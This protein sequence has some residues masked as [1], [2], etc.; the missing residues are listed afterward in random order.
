VLLELHVL[1][2]V[3]LKATGGAE[4]ERQRLGAHHLL[5]CD[6][7][8]L[9]LLQRDDLPTRR[10]DQRPVRP[11]ER[12][13]PGSASMRAL[14][15]PGLVP[16]ARTP[17]MTPFWEPL[18]LRPPGQEL[19]RTPHPASS[20]AQDAAPVY[21]C[22]YRTR[23]LQSTCAGGGAARQDLAGLELRALPRPQRLD[24]ILRLSTH[25]QRLK[26]VL[27]RL[28]A[29]VR[30][31]CPVELPS[32]SDPH[33]AAAETQRAS[34]RCARSECGREGRAGNSPKEAPQHCYNDYPLKLSRP[35]RCA[36]RS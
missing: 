16:A 25:T 27:E 18:G 24:A 20:L 4:V 13:P 22:T 35:P 31:R 8:L 15:P 12:H 7:V 17:L 29:C 6:E 34:H 30:V 3:A 9:L 36:Q 14:M 23:A 1:D 28:R 10:A 19:D 33:D 21:R 26:S 11:A 32:S 5:R 2:D